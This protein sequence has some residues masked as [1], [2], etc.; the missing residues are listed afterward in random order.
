[1]PKIISRTTNLTAAI[2]C[3]ALFTFA[4]HAAQD[5]TFSDYDSALSLQQKDVE[6]SRYHFSGPV[7]LTGELHISLDMETPTQA[8]GDVIAM[9]FVPDQE[10]LQKL[11]KVI[12]GPYSAPIKAIAVHLTDEQLYNVFGSERQ[13]HQLSHGRDHLVRQRV[14]VM[15]RDFDVSVECDSRSYAAN[16]DSISTIYDKSLA[17]NRDI[18]IGTC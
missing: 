14:S 5:V 16:L 17:D 10:E 11:P 8:S 9:Q 2:C 15:L 13:W 3:A 4:S 1:M 6:H 18:D 7:T 12:K